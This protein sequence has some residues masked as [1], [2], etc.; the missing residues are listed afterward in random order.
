MLSYNQNKRIYKAYNDPLFLLG[1]IETNLEYIFKI[2][3]STYNV[4]TIKIIKKNNSINCDCPDIIRCKKENIF[5]K[6]ICFIYLKIAKINDNFL[7]LNNKLR[8][9]DINSIIERINN[10]DDENIINNQLISRYLS[11]TNKDKEVGN[12]RNIEDDC[13]ICF[14]KLK[15]SELIQCSIC[16]NGVHKNCLDV[17][18]KNKNTCIFCRNEFKN[19]KESKYI[20]ISL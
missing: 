18:L 10:V 4:Y 9:H 16:Q 11:S 15:D 7:F 17:W 6:H 13:P 5:C 3:G 8:T 14:D 2:S 1:L 12:I 20:N 19:K